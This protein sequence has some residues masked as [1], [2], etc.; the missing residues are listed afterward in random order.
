LG[1]TWLDYSRNMT[2]GG[3]W[4]DYS[5]NTFLLLSIQIFYSCL[6]V[7]NVDFIVLLIFLKLLCWKRY[8]SS[9]FC[10]TDI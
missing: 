10:A 3:T 2:L 1:G 4:R 7:T 6:P 5:R 9:P 8:S